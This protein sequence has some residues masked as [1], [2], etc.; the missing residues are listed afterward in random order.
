MAAMAQ[1]MGGGGR[2]SMDLGGGLADFGSQ[3][4]PVT[5]TPP[6]MAMQPHFGMY[7]LQQ[8][9]GQAA[10][11]TLGPVGNAMS[12]LGGAI[13]GFMHGGLSGA[14]AGAR[15]LVPENM[16]AA[17]YY[18]DSARAFGTRTGDAAAMGTLTAANIA[19][20]IPTA[21]LGS[22]IG[23]AA[24]GGAGIAAGAAGLLGGAALAAVP[25]AY[26]KQVGEAFKENAAIQ[27]SIQA[28][29]F[30]FVSGTNPDV[31]VERGRGFNREARSKIARGLQQEERQDV[32]YGATEYRQVLEGGMQ[33][34]LF[35]GT[36]DAEDFQQKFKGLVANVKTITTTLHTSMKEGLEVIRGM[37]DMGV[38]DPGE[39][40]RMV[41]SSEVQGRASGRTGMEMMA[42]GQTGAEM[43]R[44]TGISMARGFELNQM[45]TALIRQGL[46]RGTISRE[47]VAQAGGENALAQQQTGSAL[48]S[49]QSTIGRGMM[50]SAFNPQSG[51]LDVSR[52]L[53]PRD[54]QSMVS[55][56][57]GLG[58]QG[59][60][61]FERKQEELISQMSPM[62]MRMFDVNQSSV[63]AKTLQNAGYAKNFEDAF[64]HAGRMRGKSVE[65]IK[66]DLAMIKQD[67]EQ[68]KQDQQ[69]A[70]TSVAGQAQMEDARNR[71]NVGKKI[72]NWFRETAVEPVNRVLQDVKDSV[73]S[74]AERAHQSMTGQATVDTGFLSKEVQQIAGRNAR[75]DVGL[76]DASAT[77][78]S[79][80][81]RRIIGGQ[82][83]DKAADSFLE[84]KVEQTKVDV[85][86]R[87]DT[88]GDKET[89]QVYTVKSDT[90]ESSTFRTKEEAIEFQKKVGGEMIEPPARRAGEKESTMVK[91]TITAET[92]K[93]ETGEAFA[94]RTKEEAKA[95]Q[96]KVGGEMI[97]LGTRKV[98]VGDHMEERFLVMRKDDVEKDVK[99][100]R[101]MQISDE[102]R[103][104]SEDIKI[105][106]KALD[107]IS[108]EAEKLHK[109]GK[110]LSLKDMAKGLYG[111]DNFR[112]L[113][114]EQKA[115]VE[116]YMKA[117]GIH[118]KGALAELQ[119][120]S[121]TLGAADLVG[122]TREA[123]SD[124]AKQ[125]R[126]SI[127]QEI[128]GD[129]KLRGR[130]QTGDLRKL[131]TKEFM[132]LMDSSQ[133]EAGRA[134]S[135]RKLTGT[136][137]EDRARE[138]VSAIGDMSAS[139][140]EKTQKAF[141]DLSARVQAISKTETAFT[142]TQAGSGGSSVIGDLSKN[143]M[144]EVEKMSK[145][146]IENYKILLEYQKM[147]DGS[148]QA[149]GRR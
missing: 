1:L 100:K 70:I 98:K 47:T 60:L 44:G 71:F 120:S 61:G 136:L 92:V 65:Q 88:K 83:S 39:I 18:Q 34:D 129:P 32:R 13:G 138:L 93:S 86:V 145:Q 69:V 131:S 128:G 11:G 76:I 22:A 31:D 75:G 95:F 91:E 10:L 37:R 81:Y 135:V 52:M 51:T 50:M 72:S 140:K 6:A 27:E 48:A 30:R 112:E 130:V 58:A 97:G 115:V 125:L 80:I 96:K 142:G 25:A 15:G 126:E 117:G 67:P 103:K 55:G 87:K 12:T 79:D 59:I 123:L 9:M 108:L 127:T 29:S 46:E 49:F 147:L 148:L 143:T 45:N 84:K 99:Q 105:D 16:T 21:A 110:N 113:T 35:S 121:S 85:M 89:A 137:G 53:A 19:A 38:T 102:D 43:F 73:A 24:F 109:Q 57:A 40:N 144:V 7:Q 111:T 62:Q 118:T 94:F 139:S 28:G 77:P 82:T 56:A 64:F 132:E 68:F 107:N 4:R 42:I 41:L 114:G 149:A 14:V 33:L 66:T 5:Y 54:A 122:K 106:D 133:S 3:V 104:K 101:E 63:M 78:V 146:L 2:N 26:F 36:K 116:K 74:T 17:E 141:G 23:S 134:G 20:S 119:G 90:G 8:T 124:E